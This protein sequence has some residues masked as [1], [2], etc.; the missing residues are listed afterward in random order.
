MPDPAAV[1]S[2]ETALVT[3]HSLKAHYRQAGL[4][5]E[6]LDQRYD[7]VIQHLGPLTATLSASH[8]LAFP[9][10]WA[11]AVEATSAASLAGA[12][13]PSDAG[14]AA[15]DVASQ[16][17]RRRVVEAVAGLP[18][19]TV[20]LALKAQANAVGR[21]HADSD[22]RVAASLYTAIEPHVHG[23]L[24]KALFIGR[25]CDTMAVYTHLVCLCLCVCVC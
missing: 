19:P 9:P 7:F 1:P 22:L 16:A 15:D 25:V 20:T 12:L 2:R 17:V 4:S 14:F 10:L 24:D 21:H 11:T 6:D 23:R 8:P 13:G 5:R 3:L 18:E